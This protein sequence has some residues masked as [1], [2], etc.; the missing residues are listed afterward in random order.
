M[1]MP[2]S[3]VRPFLACLLLALLAACANGG[4]RNELRDRALFAYAGAVRWGQ[5]DDALSLV[6]PVYL[7]KH[8]FTALDRSRFEQVRITGYDVKGSEQLD[9]NRL[10]QIVEIRLVNEHT[11][12]E[13]SIVDRQIW[14]WDEA[15]KTWWL[16][17]G[18][19]DIT[20]TR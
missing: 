19:P 12:A 17:T 5:I 11:Q 18:L 6:D 15:R 16:T 4:S 13:R 8:P 20:A 9:E 1:R 14:Q 7:E 10:G 3:F 2:L